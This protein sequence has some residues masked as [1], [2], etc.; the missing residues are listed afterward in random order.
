MYC[1]CY[2][3]SIIW[4]NTYEWFVLFN[5]ELFTIWHLGNKFIVLRKCRLALPFLFRWKAESLTLDFQRSSELDLLIFFI[6]NLDTFSKGP[7]NPHQTCLLSC[8]IRQA[9]RR[10]VLVLSDYFELARLVNKVAIVFVF[11]TLTPLSFYSKEDPY[12]S[13]NDFKHFH[14]KYAAFKLIQVIEMRA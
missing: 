9:V 10:P 1:V 11:P 14:H 5:G 2:E 3:R 6:C 13:P 8:R 12:P 7:F 4:V